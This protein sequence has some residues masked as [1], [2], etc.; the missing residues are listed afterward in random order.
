MLTIPL[1]VAENIP[2]P[3]IRLPARGPWGDDQASAFRDLADTVA[4]TPGL[5]W[6]IWTENPQERRAGGIYLFDDQPSL[7]RYLDEHTAHL[8]GFGIT[9]IRAIVF[10]VNEPLTAI[11]AGPTTPDA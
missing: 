10:D 3:R 2:D 7:E 1:A 4:R 5:R 9:D 6:K 11:T 8:R